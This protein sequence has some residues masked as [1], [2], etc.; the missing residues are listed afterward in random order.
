MSV[1][2]TESSSIGDLRL[3]PGKKCRHYSHGR[4]LREEAVNPGLRREH[5]CL[6]LLRLEERYDALLKRL[7]AFELSER[8]S[9]DLLSKLLER[10]KEQGG[11]C[12]RKVTAPE[13]D[14]EGNALDCVHA[15]GHVCLLQM[16]ACEGVCRYYEPSGGGKHE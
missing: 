1:K 9:M 8:R 4:C 2:N 12:E 13:P 16:P 11:R 6:E 15:L 7:D 14:R 10:H 3:F 5:V